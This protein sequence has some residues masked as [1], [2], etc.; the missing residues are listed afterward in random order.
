MLFF[1]HLQL[2]L[3]QLGH[4]LRLDRGVDQRPHAAADEVQQ[5]MIVQQPSD[6]CEDAALF[7][8]RDVR[9][10]GEHAVAPRQAE[11]IVQA[12]ECFFV[13]RLVERRAFDRCQHAF[14]QVDEHLLRR[15]D[16]QPAERGTAD[17]D[18]LGGV[19]QRADMP[20]GH[21][22]AAEHGADHDDSTNDD[23]HLN[24]GFVL[25]ATSRAAL[26]EVEH[27]FNQTCPPRFGEILSQAAPND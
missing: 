16:D 8:L 1:H 12:L 9:L 14:H 21:R 17:R 11:Q 18:E 7:R 20:A 19:N 2:G 3:Q 15:A 6:T 13:G 23:N 25:G 24:N 10:E 26:G 5:V 4:L 27:R 22:E